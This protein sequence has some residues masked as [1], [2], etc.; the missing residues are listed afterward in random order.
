MLFVKILKKTQFIC[1]YTIALDVY[2]R[3]GGKIMNLNDYEMFL[4][5][6]GYLKR[7]ITPETNNNYKNNM[8]VNNNKF[9]SPQEGFYKGNLEAASYVPYNN[10]Q[11][12][13]PVITSEQERM[14]EQIQAY[15]FAAHDL[16][17]YLDVHP[18][19]NNAIESYNSYNRQ[20]E[21]LTNQYEK[22]YG[23]INLDNNTGLERSP[24][25]WN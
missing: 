15:S 19:D 5:N 6:N 18:N 10:M 2:N 9:V 20:V 22:Q 1:P 24:W 23:P 13:K 25:A 8:T 7:C 16:N 3:L 14:M 12:I 21:E 17:L 4:I 11:V